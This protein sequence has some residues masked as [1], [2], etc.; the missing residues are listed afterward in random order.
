[1]NYKQAR[2][3]SAELQLLGWTIRSV[4]VNREWLATLVFTRYDAHIRRRDIA[5]RFCQMPG[6]RW[7]VRIR[8]AGGSTSTSLGDLTRIKDHVRRAIIRAEHWAAE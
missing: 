2:A 8:D 7:H 4:G 1:M 5:I 6:T 3:Y